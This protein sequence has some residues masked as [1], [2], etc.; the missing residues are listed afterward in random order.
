MSSPNEREEK[1]IRLDLS[2]EDEDVRRLAV[3]RLSSLGLDVA[4]PLLIECLGDVSWRVR[5]SAV[6]RLA[7]LADGDAIAAALIAALSDGDNPGRRNAAVDALVRTGRAAV[8]R[9][10]EA[11]SSDDPDV[12]KFVVDS[13]AGIGDPR[14]IQPLIGCI[15]DSDPNVRAAAADALGAIGGREAERALLEAAVDG[16]QDT[17]V[18]FSALHAIAGLGFEVRARDLQTALEDPVLRPAAVEILGRTR[19]DAEADDVLLKSISARSRASREAGMRATLQRIACADGNLSEFVARVRDALI[20]APTAIDASI[21]RLGEADLATRLVIAQFFGLANDARVVLP[22]LRSASVDALED[23]AMGA[24]EEI[25]EVAE[26]TL[27][28]AWPELDAMERQRA[29]RLFA[30]LTGTSSRSRLVKAL[31]DPDPLVR[32]ESA[33]ALSSRGIVEAV[34]PLLRCLKLASAQA[35]ENGTDELQTVTDALAEL[36]GA[37]D[38][39]DRE[40]MVETLAGELAGANGPVRIAIARVLA[41]M[42]RPGDDEVVALLLRDPSPLV[43]RAAVE[44]LASVFSVAGA[45]SLHLAIADE[46]AEVRM[47]AARSLGA[48]ALPEVLPDLERLTR[49]EDARVRAAAVRAIGVCFGTS[50]DESVSSQCRLLL[51]PAFEDEALVV[52][53]ALEATLSHRIPLQSPNVLL[54]RDEPEIVRETIRCVGSHGDIEDLSNVIPLCGH[55]DWSVRA[56]AIQVLA[57]RRVSRA[58][59]EILRRVDLERDDFVRRVTLHALERLEG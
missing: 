45:E 49:D 27:D 35:E 55:D 52:L 28:T 26:S 21:E 19:G 42:G 6:D 25:A 33:S 50:T 9:L 53:A 41:R 17:L 10:I 8:A 1:S 39:D 13:L 20:E 22:L 23:A 36:A 44:S 7:V 59:P 31:E 38:S 14:A 56:E 24:L 30:K 4:V 29:C 57:D 46:S 47:A 43:R 18:R 12:R 16:L 37:V 11:L 40:H 48:C 54:Q 5:K 15:E 34:T 3:E 2:S 58:V 32:S 51:A